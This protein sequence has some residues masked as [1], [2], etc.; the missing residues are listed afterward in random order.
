MRLIP[1]IIEFQSSS[2]PKA[3]CNRGHFK[4]A[5]TNKFNNNLRDPIIPHI[6]REI[7]TTEKIAQ[8]STDK[9]IAKP[10]GI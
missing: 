5:D 1:V 10:P 2:S 7:Y 8:T 9:A 4:H 6:C 3:G